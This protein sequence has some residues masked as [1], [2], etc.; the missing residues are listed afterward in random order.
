MA[1]LGQYYGRGFPLGSTLT[2]LYMGDTYTAA[3]GGVWISNAPTSPFAY[4]ATY[5]NTPTVLLSPHALM[6]GPRGGLWLGTAGASIAYKASGTLYC[7]AAGTS[8]IDGDTTNGYNYFTTTNGGASWTTRSFPNTKTYVVG[9][10]ASLFVGLATSATTNGIITGTDAISWN[11]FTATSQATVSDIVSNGSTQ[12]LIF[13]SSGTV[14]NYSTDSG[15]TWAAAT[16]TGPSGASSGLNLGQ[17]TWN[18]GAS[19]YIGNTGVVGQYQTSP[20]G[21]TWTLRA[22]QATFSIYSQSFSAQTKYASNSTVTVAIGL[23]GFFATTTDGLTWSNHGY[24]VTSGQ[25]GGNP[26]SFTYDGTRYVAHYT[27]RIF[28][29]TNG[30]TWT[31][32]RPTG[33]LPVYVTNDRC[34]KMFVNSSSLL[35]KAMLITDPTATT[36]ATVAS[37]FATTGI[38]STMTYMRIL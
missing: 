27:E 21:A 33:S 28:Y 13:P 2:M 35:Q 22:T 36:A 10:T 3:D 32:G 8:T 5:A 38:V 16:I 7:Y 18:A 34:V 24:M 9:Y 14:A 25:P 1:N 20:T 30:T 29:S 11:S 15:A 19:L 4:S 37:I 17:V 23:N 12:I 26:T 31:E 6:T